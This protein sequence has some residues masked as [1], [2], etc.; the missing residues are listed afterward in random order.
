MC[1]TAM[2]ASDMSAEP[3]GPAADGPADNSIE[4]DLA[5]AAFPDAGCFAA[6]IT[7]V[8]EARAPDASA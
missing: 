6:A 5:D 3:F 1:P 7:Q 8:I 2:A 4:I